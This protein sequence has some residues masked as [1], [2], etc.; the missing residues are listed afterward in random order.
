M[1]SHTSVVGSPWLHVPV[2]G[3]KR[4]GRARQL[5]P[6]TLPFL[7]SVSRT[8]FHAV[9]TSSGVHPLVRLASA[10]LFSPLA[11]RTQSSRPPG[12]SAPFAP[13]VRLPGESELG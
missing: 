9:L 6:V 4:T 1:H 12:I 11:R 13:N 3:G 10:R 5:T 2:V 8:S 7:G